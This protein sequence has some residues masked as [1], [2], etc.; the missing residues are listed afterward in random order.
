MKPKNIHSRAYNNRKLECKNEGMSHEECL[1]E[2]RKAGYQAVQDAIK[3]G[4]IDGVPDA[5]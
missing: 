1:A 3:N 5:N 2:A 4:I